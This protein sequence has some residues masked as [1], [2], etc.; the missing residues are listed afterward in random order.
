ME[1]E[2]NSMSELYRLV[3]SFAP[4]PHGWGKFRLASPETHFFLCDFLDMDHGLPEPAS[5][6]ARVAEIHRNS[7]SPTGKFGFQVPN[8]HGKIPQVVDW[9]S[10][11]ASFF[12]KL[13]TRFFNIELEVNGSWP[14]YEDAFDK[15]VQHVIPQ[16]LGPLQ[17]N[18][19]VLK[20]CLVHG[21]LWEENTA[22]NLATGEPVV[23]D[24]SCLY[25]HNEYEL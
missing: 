20:P 4:K 12:A 18:G 10:S 16:V 7:E 21:D 25:A 6:C 3:P 1:G 17:E 22:T 11:W 9:N 24:A 13:F 8:C 15:V 14:E 2:Y 23:F 5:F 19:R